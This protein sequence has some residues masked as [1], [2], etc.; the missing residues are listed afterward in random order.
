[1]KRHGRIFFFFFQE[2]IYF[3]E[4]WRNLPLQELRK[5]QLVPC[6]L[7]LLAICVVPL[8][9]FVNVKLNVETFLPISEHFL[10]CFFLKGTSY[11][12]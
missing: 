9:G 8:A 1:M 4:N 5:G 10:L 7:L 6:S 3:V 2:S 11:I 12:I